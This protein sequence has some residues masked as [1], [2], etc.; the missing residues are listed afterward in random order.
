M[1]DD[2]IENDQQVQEVVENQTEQ[3]QIT[4]NNENVVDEAPKER[5]NDVNIRKLRE[6]AERLQ[7]E[8][9]EA[10]RLAQELQQ[11]RQQQPE[12]DDDIN[13][14]D[15]DFAEGKHLSKLGRKIKKLEQQIAQYNQYT[16]QSTA[17]I[18]LKTQYPDF[19]S[20]VNQD[21]IAQLREEYPD[22]AA[23]LHANNDFMS[24]ASS[25]Y[26]L[27]KKLGI[28]QQDNYSQDRERAQAN[29]AKPR[30]A[31][32]VGPQGGDSPLTKANAFANGLTD[33]LKKYL[34]QEMLDASRK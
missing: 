3:T 7:R 11:Q 17:E 6:N 33:D 21:T 13:L 20:V 32:S 24:K 14:G 26:T 31:V 34:Y 8:R 2:M 19:E 9:D 29:A 5:P 28:Y 30:P 15:D 1:I 22:I 16:S 23:S 4:D 18:K 25:A 10:V 27:I 12:E